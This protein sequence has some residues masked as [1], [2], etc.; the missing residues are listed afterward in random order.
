MPDRPHAVT[1]WETDVAKRQAQGK[2]GVPLRRWEMLFA[3]WYA[4]QP[5]RPSRAV[6]LAKASEFAEV[7][8]DLATY[9][10]M[11]AK[12]TYRAYF[13]QYAKD[14][15]RAARKKLKKVYQKIPKLYE[16]AIGWAG[17]A[18]SVGMARAAAPLIALGVDRIDPKKMAGVGGPV[19]AI[20]IELSTKQQA[21]IASPDIPEADYEVL[22]T[23]TVSS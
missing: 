18:E 1:K 19:M 8:I 2:A 17:N 5:K 22:T 13:Q 23:E 7:D 9:R 4:D 10:T 3:E 20:R 14:D 21:L 16:D 12:K 15:L 6:A 11:L